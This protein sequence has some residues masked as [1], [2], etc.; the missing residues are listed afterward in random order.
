MKRL[1]LIA[2]VSILAGG[3]TASALAVETSSLAGTWKFRLDPQN[4]GHI[5]NWNEQK[6]T[7]N[8]QLPGSTDQAGYGT[9][10]TGP[11]NGTLSRPYVY[12]GP[13]WYQTAFTIPDSWRG[14]RITLFLER[15]H[16]QTEV[17]IDGR[18]LGMQDSLCTP[19]V[20]DLGQSLAPGKHGLTICVDN[21]YK[22]DVGT[23]AHSVTD[24][25]QTNWNGIVG[26]MELRA[27]DPIWIE[28]VQVYPN[29]QEKKADI[30][31]TIRNITGKPAGGEI[32][33]AARVSG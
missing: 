25:T 24:H 13:A 4:V 11:A 30:K 7:D 29:L 10:T 19:H 18:P 2:I 8:I 9:K 33:A 22:I 1:A 26:R 6:F 16:W 21:A 20:Y 32:K 28:A 27:S 12:E 3:V 17:W 5:Q 14:K 31:I 23:R 15:C